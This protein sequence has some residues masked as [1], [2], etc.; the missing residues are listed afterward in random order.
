MDPFSSRRSEP[1]IPLLS[2]A[3]DN[4]SLENKVSKLSNQLSSLNLGPASQ[5]D[6][7]GVIT[8]VRRLKGQIKR[9]S[10][11]L[12]DLSRLGNVRQNK[13]EEEV[14]QH[15]RKLDELYLSNLQLSSQLLE[16]TRNRCQS[17]PDTPDVPNV[18]FTGNIRETRRFVYVMKER[19]YEHGHCFRSE[20][21]KINWEVRHFRSIDGNLG[22]SVPSFNWWIALLRE[23]ARLQDI[24]PGSASVEDPYV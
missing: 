23:N 16:V 6:L 12:R 20:K 11:N 3:R 21:S 1:S 22:D 24:N 9:L 7:D 13:L 8:E 17:Y 19:L 4:P 18:S 15:R 14:G 5:G 2:A 10:D